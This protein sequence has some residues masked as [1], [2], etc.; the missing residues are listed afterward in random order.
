[1]LF[2]SERNTFPL[3]VSGDGLQMSFIVDRLS[4][5]VYLDSGRVYASFM[6]EATL[7][8]YNLPLMNISSNVTIRLDAVKIYKLGSIWG[9]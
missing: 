1:M 5:E 7:P 4:Y 6:E 9:K 3:S 2:R 8:D